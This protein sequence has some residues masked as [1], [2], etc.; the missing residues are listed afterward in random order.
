MDGCLWPS[1]ILPLLLLDVRLHGLHPSILNTLQESID[2]EVL[3]KAVYDDTVLQLGLG[4]EF[5]FEQYIFCIKVDSNYFLINKE[6][7]KV[8]SPFK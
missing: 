6:R 7:K 3:A 4:G 5:D 2:S 8:F 1:N